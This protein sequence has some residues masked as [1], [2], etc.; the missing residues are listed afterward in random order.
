[1]TKQTKTNNSNYLIDT[2][3]NKVN[4]LFVLSFEDEED[5]TSFSKYYMPKA[6]IKDFKVS[7]DGKRFFRCASK[8]QRRKIRK[9]MKYVKIII[10]QLTIYWI[11]Y[12]FQS[13]IN[14]LK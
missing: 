14:L 13:T 2:T 4:R 6:E 8:K 11:I 7:N 12:I 3:F 1:M 10:I 9:N 5:R